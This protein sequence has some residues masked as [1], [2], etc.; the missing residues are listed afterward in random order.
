MAYN[1]IQGLPGVSV[2]ASAS[3]LTPSR[4]Q[5]K[6]L[7]IPLPTSYPQY[8]GTGSSSSFLDKVNNF[9]GSPLAGL[10]L[11][12]GSTLLGNL[13]NIGNQTRVNEANLALAREQN[14][15][16]YQMWK[17][18]NEYNTPKN[19]MKRLEEAGLNPMLAYGMVSSQPSTAITSAELGNQQATAQL[20]AP[21][22]QLGT[23]YALQQKQLDMQKEQLEIADYNARTQR[24]SAQAD[25]S[26]KAR[27]ENLITEQAKTE[28]E[29]RTQLQAS[30]RSLDASTKLTITE[31]DL[32]MFD[33]RMKT[34]YGEQ[35][36]V[37]NMNLVLSQIGANKAQV[38]KL[39]AEIKYMPQYAA[40]AQMNALASMKNAET[41]SYNAITQRMLGLSAIDVNEQ[42]I[43][44][45]NKR[46]DKICAEIGFTKEQTIAVQNV[47]STY[48]VEKGV[49]LV[50]AV[51]DI[52]L[53]PIT[54]FTGAL[55]SVK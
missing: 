18:N 54:A 35:E 15:F 1:L 19:Q 33:K 5:I 22:L 34:L 36:Y 17:E 29:K 44:E 47:N 51:Q 21:N 11:N 10:G 23:E 40:A 30:V 38:R 50:G 52:Y 26:L 48:Y 53:K 12:L 46:I 42:N 9:L 2:G 32:R 39:L 3:A 14:E 55:G 43:K 6:R 13:L 25:V 16:N 7:N 28:K 4:V 37:N 41:N 45:S 27:T 8:V 31:N 24:M 49:Q 20:G